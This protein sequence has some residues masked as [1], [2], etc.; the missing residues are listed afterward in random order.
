MLFYSRFTSLGLLVVF[1][2][3]A[4]AVPV[5][6]GPSLGLQVNIVSESAEPGSVALVQK[7]RAATIFVDKTDWAGVLRAASDLQ[8]DVERVSGVSRSLRPGDVLRE[9]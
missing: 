3:V 2:I 6:A 8:A 1:V 9:K 4:T 5:H 7:K